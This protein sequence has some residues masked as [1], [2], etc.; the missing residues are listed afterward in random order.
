[1]TVIVLIVAF[2]VGGLISMPTRLRLNI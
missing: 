1:V 2:F